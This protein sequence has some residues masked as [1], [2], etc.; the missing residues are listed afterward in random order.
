VL[1]TPEQMTPVLTMLAQTMPALTTPVQR[2]AGM[3]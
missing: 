2:L 3:Q 1:R